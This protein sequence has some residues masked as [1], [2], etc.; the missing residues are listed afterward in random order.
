MVQNNAE[1]DAIIIGTGQG[2]MPLAQALNQAGWKTGIIE[3]KYVGG[4]CI[5][6]G[7]TPTKTMVASARIAYLARRAGDFGVHV[8]SVSV[9]LEEV[10]QR[11][12]GVVESFREGSEQRLTDAEHIELIHG[13]GRFIDTH[14]VEVELHNSGSRRLTADHIFINTGG[15]PRKLNIPGIEDIEP[16]DSTSIMEL[17][18]LPDHLI[19]IGGGYIGIEFGQMF[20]RFGSK[21][22]IVQ[23]GDQLLA[24][25]DRD[26]AGEVLDILRDDGIEVYLNSEVTHIQKDSGGKITF[27]ISSSEKE[28]NIEGSH[29]LVAAGRVP[30][31]DDLHL[32][33]AGIEQNKKGQ[34]VVDDKLE[35]NVDGIYAIGDVRPGPQFT[36][37]SYDDYRILQTNILEGGDASTGGRLVPYTVFI[38]PQLGRIGLSEEQAKAQHIDYRVAK[39]PMEYVARA[40][41]TGET[42]GFMKALVDSESKKI[43]GCAILGSQGGEIMSMLQ[44]AMMGDL[45]YTALK[46]GIFTHPLFSEALNSL[47]FTLE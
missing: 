25:E 7:C 13:H 10:R 2:G 8:P 32:D 29:V 19:V 42:R 21:V 15:R 3:R 44:I 35:T 31:T 26:V 36:H 20:R 4:T 24:R 39:L 1:Y 12:Q 38:D 30:N 14:T 27:T 34:V 41:E 47:F 17:N 45:P 40:I 33:A 46:E 9:N 28:V 16:L 37:I 22:S 23:R 43:L 18:D 5:N 11:K 6:Y